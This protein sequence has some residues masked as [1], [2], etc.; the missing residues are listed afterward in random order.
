MPKTKKLIT[1]PEQNEHYK[2]TE[3]KRWDSFLASYLK[4]YPDRKVNY[5]KDYPDR[6]VN[7]SANNNQKRKKK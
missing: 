3:F 6:K 1:V 4:D 5:L 2:G 7:P